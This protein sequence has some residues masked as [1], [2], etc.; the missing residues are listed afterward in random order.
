[1]MIKKKTYTR[2]LMMLYPLYESITIKYFVCLAT[3]TVP[4]F[5]GGMFH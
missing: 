1:M 2:F 4:D 5:L 3:Q